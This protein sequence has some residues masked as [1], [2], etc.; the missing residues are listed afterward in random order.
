MTKVYLLDT[1]I[2]SHMMR[3]TTGL[4]AR[5][6]AAIARA[7]VP[8][9]M[10]TSVIVRCELEFGLVRRPNQRLKAAY[11]KIVPLLDVM[12]LTDQIAEYYARLRTQLEAVGTPI[13]PNDA[14]IAA[15]ALA[16]DATLVSA[17]AEFLRVPG[18]HVENWL[19]A[20]IEA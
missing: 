2:I 1:N 14:L 17:D 3:E 13:G 4:A 12:P 9:K 19:D 11:E 7:N 6:F 10:T 8:A 5:R 20:K 16:L 18:L 15:H